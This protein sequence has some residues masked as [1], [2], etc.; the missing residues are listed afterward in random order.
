MNHILGGGS[1]TS[2]LY[3]EIREKRG[4]AYGAYSYLASYDHGAVLGIGTATRADAAPQTVDIIRKEIE[5]MATA[6]PTQAEL[7]K[8]KPAGQLRRV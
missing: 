5:R 7:D 1:F 2:W 8:A 3:E 6:G 4:L